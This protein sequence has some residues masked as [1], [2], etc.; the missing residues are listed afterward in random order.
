MRDTARSNGKGL[1]RILSRTEL[2]VQRTYPETSKRN[3]PK[4]VYIRNTPRLV[5]SVGRRVGTSSR[6]KGFF[7]PAERRLSSSS[8]TSTQRGVTRL[9]VRW[10][11]V[12]P[13][14]LSSRL[15]AEGSLSSARLTTDINRFQVTEIL[16][17][18]TLLLITDILAFRLFRHLSMNS[19]TD[20]T[21]FHKPL[22]K[23]SRPKK[24]STVN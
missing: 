6:W 17:G 2:I 13:R 18:R 12:S 3:N 10:R 16:R 20:P 15:V 22:H 14:S 24:C 23:T 9:L 11:E 8:L 5:H 7:R 4:V 1:S 21:F 19:A